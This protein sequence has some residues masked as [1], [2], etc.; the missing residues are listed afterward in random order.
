MKKLIL[1][2]SLF[3]GLNAADVRIEDL[4]QKCQKKHMHFSSDLKIAAIQYQE[5]PDNAPL[6]EKVSRFLNLIE[7][8]NRLGLLYRR[9]NSIWRFQLECGQCSVCILKPECTLHEFNMAYYGSPA[10]K[11]IELEFLNFMKAGRIVGLKFD[12]QV[13]PDK[14][15]YMFRNDSGTIVRTFDYPNN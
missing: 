12:V 3:L 10:I 11:P 13:F 7:T 6:H 4:T 1:L 8:S 14:S 15:V 2:S 9:S 5:L